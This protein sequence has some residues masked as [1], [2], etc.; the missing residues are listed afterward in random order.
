MEA[1]DI[2]ATVTLGAPPVGRSSFKKIYDKM[3]T[4]S[5]HFRNPDGDPVSDPE[6]KESYYESRNKG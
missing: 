1:D 5:F 3:I 6:S 4:L 2:I